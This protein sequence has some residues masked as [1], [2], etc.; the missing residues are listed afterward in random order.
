MTRPRATMRA[1]CRRCV[2][3]ACAR[4]RSLRRLNSG[5]ATGGECLSGQLPQL[6][7][8]LGHA[9]TCLDRR[10]CTCLPR[11]SNQARSRRW[12]RASCDLEKLAERPKARPIS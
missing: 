5:H 12:A 7:G 9:E 6:L 3:R 8:E 10:A 4:L 11:G 1:S 2:A